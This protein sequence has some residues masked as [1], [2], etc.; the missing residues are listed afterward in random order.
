M[1]TSSAQRAKWCAQR[2][3]SSEQTAN[4]RIEKAED[5]GTFFAMSVVK[6]APQARPKTT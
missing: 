6:V 5:N 4:S 3:Q 1:I 2:A